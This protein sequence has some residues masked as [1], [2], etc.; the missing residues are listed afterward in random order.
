MMTVALENHF[1]SHFV[2]VLPPVLGH[3]GGA[4]DGPNGPNGPNVQGPGSDHEH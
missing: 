1:V 2:V 3:A 4:D